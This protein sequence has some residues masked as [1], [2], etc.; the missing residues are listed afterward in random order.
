[1]SA[2]NVSRRRLIAG[3]VILAISFAPWFGV[4]LVPFF[5]LSIENSA[6]AVGGLILLAEILGGLALLV[7]GREGYL[8]VRA[9][10]RRKRGVE[11][12]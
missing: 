11:E 5:G 10:W 1:M 2:P 3:G 7:L 12:P 4:P 9:W 6:Y 8:A